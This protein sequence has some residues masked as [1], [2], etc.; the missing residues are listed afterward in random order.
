[1]L[2]VGDS[3]YS[4]FLFK[5]CWIGLVFLVVFCKGEG[6]RSEESIGDIENLRKITNKCVFY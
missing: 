2:Y 4:D 5:C 3:L 1:M 6:D